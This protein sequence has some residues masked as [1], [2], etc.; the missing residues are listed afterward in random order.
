MKI[1]GIG[2]TMQYNKTPF[3]LAILFAGCATSSQVR[4]EQSQTGTLRFELKE[5]PFMVPYKG[6][7][8]WLITFGC[9]VQ[10][11]TAPVP[12]K[13]LSSG[14]V[15]EMPWPAVCG[16]RP[17][18]NVRVSVVINWMRCEPFTNRQVTIPRPIPGQIVT[19]LFSVPC[20]GGAVSANQGVTSHRRTLFDK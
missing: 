19:V 3:F 5:Q 13:T 6:N 2:E 10:G 11:D 14:S 18:A 17:K 7:V 20:S 12:I 9:G 1:S 8:G 15:L 4:E 16:A